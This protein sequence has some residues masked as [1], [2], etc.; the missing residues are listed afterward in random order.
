MA[1]GVVFGDIGTS[2]LSAMRTAFA[3]DN[4]A[5]QVTSTDVYGVTSLILWS[6]TVVVTIKYVAFVLRADNGGE[7]GVMALLALTRDAFPRN[8][9]R[10]AAIVVLLGLVGA[11][12]FYGDL[13]I[14]PAI[15]VL[16][17]V[18]GL[19]VAA[20]WGTGRVGVAFGPV[21][22]VWFLALFVSGA[23][24]L[25]TD[26]SA[27]RVISPTYAAVFVVE[28]PFDAF[29]FLGAVVLAITGAE[30]LYADLGHVGRRPIR[31]A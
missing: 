2:P 5:V 15:S 16:S 22:L 1:L 19:G 3:T 28:Q 21:M 20:R 8:G 6:I 25:R 23:W 17:A 27:L 4:S 29:I 13:V 11:S 10:L 9:K 30:A 14:T 7:G 24:S 26:P 12:L 31:I 18:E